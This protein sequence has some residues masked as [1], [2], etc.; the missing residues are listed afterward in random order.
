MPWERKLDQSKPEIPWFALLVFTEDELRLEKPLEPTSTGSVTVAI[1]SFLEAS[2]SKQNLKPVVN[3]TEPVERRLYGLDVK[4]TDN[5]SDSLICNTV[6]L[7]Y[8]L[9]YKIAP[10]LNKDL[11]YLAHCRQINT[12]DK[13]VLGLKDDGWFSVI[14]A[15]RFPKAMKSC[16]VEIVS[17]KPLNPLPN[18]YIVFNEAKSWQLIRYDENGKECTPPINIVELSGLQGEFTKL[19]AELNELNAKRES[20]KLP[21]LSLENLSNTH[22]AKIKSIIRAYHDQKFPNDKPKSVRNI[23]HLVSLEGCKELLA[24]NNTP[25]EKKT[26]QLLSL[27]SWS[28]ICLPEPQENF[29]ILMTQMMEDPQMGDDSKNIPL[30]RFLPKSDDAKNLSP[31]VQ[32]RFT[33]GYLPVAYTVRTGEKTM[34][35]YRGPFI[36]GKVSSLP[37]LPLVS[38]T[39]SGFMI[40]DEKTGIFD[41]SYATAWQLGQSL[42]LTDAHFAQMLVELRWQESN[43]LDAA[44]AA[45]DKSSTEESTTGNENA[46]KKLSLR[47]HKSNFFKHINSLASLKNLMGRKPSVLTV[48]AASTTATGVAVVDTKADDKNSSGKTAP[49][50]GRVQRL[51]L[52]PEERVK[53]QQDKIKSA[54]YS[55]AIP[56]EIQDWLAQLR[57]LVGLPFHYLVS[58]EKLLPMESIRFFYIDTNWLNTLTKG[59]L[60]I[61]VHSD[62]HHN[63]NGVIFNQLKKIYDS[64]DPVFGFLLRS[65]VVSSLP[66]LAIRADENIKDPTVNVTRQERL[67][68]NVL[69]CLFDGVPQQIS[70][71]EPQE[72]LSFGVSGDGLDTGFIEL[73]ELDEKIGAGKQKF[74]ED[75]KNQL[76]II[77]FFREPGSRVL[78]FL[79]IRDTLSGKEKLD[80][81]PLTTSDL[82]V[83]LIRS[84]EEVTFKMA[85]NHSS[86]ANFT[87]NNKINTGEQVVFRWQV[88]DV[89]HCALFNTKNNSSVRDNIVPDEKGWCDFQMS[90]NDTAIYYVEGYDKNNVP[91]AKSDILSVR[92]LKHPSLVNFTVNNKIN[93]GEQVVFR[94]QV[95][96][97]H[98]CA[99]F[100]TQDNSSV[101]NKIVPDEKGLCSFLM[102]PN[103]TASYY[104][105]GYDDNNICAVKSNILRVQVDYAIRKI[106][107]PSKGSQTR[108]TSVGKLELSDSYLYALDVGHDG[109]SIINTRKNSY[110]HSINIGII[111]D[112]VLSAKGKLYVIYL[113]FGSKNNT[114]SVISVADISSI[115]L[116]QMIGVKNTPTAMVLNADGSLLYI[117][118]GTKGDISVINT[119][120]GKTINEIKEANPVDIMLLSPTS[121][122]LYV[123]FFGISSVSFIDTV[124]Y[125]LIRKIHV[126]AE[127][128]A[129]KLNLDGSLLYVVSDYNKNISVINTNTG[130]IKNTIPIGDGLKA[131]A[132]SPNG[133]WLYIANEKNANISVM[134]TQNYQIVATVKVGINPTCLKLNSDG[135]KLYISCR[136]EVYVMN[137]EPDELKPEVAASRILV[138]VP[139]LSSSPYSS[140]ASPVDSKRD[141]KSDMKSNGAAASVATAAAA[142]PTLTLTP[143]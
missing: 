134:N 13:E 84:P 142:S 51:K 132:L 11:P 105:E 117:A 133:L 78:D 103:D 83:Q 14:I 82:A 106:T 127:I 4:V 125:Q 97:V 46:P 57:H 96:D 108:S 109:I 120:N 126:G 3:I 135:S 53:L 47:Q 80:K 21:K 30:L 112:F 6:T 111:H 15:N 129:L 18:G 104:V 10:D 60:S 65:A 128:I 52:T 87:V 24:V 140:F 55:I 41:V 17:K 33:N 31:D 44:L 76:P 28:F 138:N 113:D 39:G 73:R 123:A 67:S 141:M 77:T 50:L 102:S 72:Q 2:K 115:K 37:T 79:K 81:N 58:D 86:I 139:H 12:G 42:A 1:N 22:K 85:P 29:G 92:V 71:C 116:V 88:V 23:V 119:I 54:D 110:V 131:I 114:V 38:R 5:K 94:W 75:E 68:S 63:M 143:S 70:I 64:S 36:P 62:H 69:L 48:P 90:S 9:F 19:Q 98:H 26:I 100:N 45:Q 122:R 121:H 95:V 107:I 136:N 74:S 91:V 35:W 124:N 25:D 66:G 20:Q 99:L 34:A 43:R 32:N 101:G 8:D 89:H 137:C 40:Y 130:Q 27:A 118:N 61:G 7:P 93:A 49:V 56:T 16:Y 59:V